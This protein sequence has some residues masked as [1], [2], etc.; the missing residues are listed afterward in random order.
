MVLPAQHMH[1]IAGIVLLHGMGLGQAALDQAGLGRAQRPALVD[2]GER[3]TWVEL[4]PALLQRLAHAVQRLV[5][6]RR[7][8]GQHH[9]RRVQVQRQVFAAR[10]QA[11]S[12]ME[13]ALRLLARGH[14][15]D[16]L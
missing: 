14:G 10:K 16:G 12:A 13:Q 4:L 2:P 8:A 3:L 1:Q 5:G 9:G 15:G 6:Q 11:A 7:K